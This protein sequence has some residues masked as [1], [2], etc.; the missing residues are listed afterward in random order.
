MAAGASS[1]VLFIAV[2]PA[3]A[4]RIDVLT[5]DFICDTAPRFLPRSF[6]GLRVFDTSMVLRHRHSFLSVAHIKAPLVSVT[7]F[8][9]CALPSLHQQLNCARHLPVKLCRGWLSPTCLQATATG[10]RGRAAPLPQ[11]RHS[12]IQQY[13]ATTAVRLCCC[14][15][16]TTEEV[17]R[18]S[19]A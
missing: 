15:Y 7:L 2:L 9:L 16:R 12:I 10:R 17:L 13:N 14:Y 11:Q 19:T 8:G 4:N 18:F 1:H 6:L 3:K 5:V